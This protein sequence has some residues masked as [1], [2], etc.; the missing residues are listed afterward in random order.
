MVLDE[1]GAELLYYPGEMIFKGQNQNI[2][3]KSVYI[4]DSEIDM[5][6]AEVLEQNKEYILENR[7]KYVVDVEEKSSIERERYIDRD[8]YLYEASRFIIEKGKAS[9]GMLQR[10]FKIGFNRAVKIMDQAAELGVVGEEDGTMHRKVLMTM[11]EFEQLIDED[12]AQI[13]SGIKPE[14][15]LSKQKR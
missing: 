11:K 10:I 7:E 15:I 3:C 1:N 13:E 8:E 5:L 6:R 14:I 2:K 4:S 12:K 9:I